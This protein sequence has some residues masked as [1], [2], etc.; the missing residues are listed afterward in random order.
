M[1]KKPDDSVLKNAREITYSTLADE[2]LSRGRLDYISPNVE[3]LLGYKPGDF[4]ANR[5]LWSSIIHREDIAKV[6][7]QSKKYSGNASIKL[8]Y[9]VRHRRTGKYRT[10]EDV[11]NPRLDRKGKRIGVVGSIIDITDREA[12]KPRRRREP[13]MD[14]EFWLNESQRVAKVGSYVYDFSTGEWSGSPTLDGILGLDRS[15]RKDVESWL[16]LIHPEDR[17]SVYIQVRKAYSSSTKS[18]VEFRIV[19]WKDKKIRWIWGTGEILRDSR[20]RPVK[21]FGTVQDITERKKAEDALQQNEILFHNSFEQSAGGMALVG[22]DGK[23]RLVNNRFAEMLGFSKE[24]LLSKT[25]VSVAHPEEREQAKKSIPAILASGVKNQIIEKRLIRKDGSIIWASISVALIQDLEGKP[26]YLVANFQ[27]MTERNKFEET[28]RNERIILRTL[29][30][31]LPS[32]VY[33]KDRECRARVVN[34]AAV[35]NGGMKSESE[36]IGKTDFDFFPREIAEGFFADDQK[37][38]KE[39]KPVLDREEYFFDNEGKKHWQLT[40]KVP[41][42]DETGKVVGLVGVGTDITERKLEEE[43]HQRERILL[44]TLVDNLPNAVFVKDKEYRKVIANPAHIRRVGLSTGHDITSESEILGKTDFEVYPKHLAEEFFIDDQKVIRDGQSVI[45]REQFGVDPSGYKRWELI[46]KLPLRDEKGEIIGLVGI[47]SEITKQKSVE[48]ALERER[49]LLKTLIDNLPSAIFAKDREYRKIIVN[50]AHVK[51]VGLSVGPKAEAEILGKTDFD[52]YP[53]DL[54]EGYFNEDRDIVEEGRQVLNR[55]SLNIDKNGERHWDLISKIPFRNSEGKIAGMVGITTDITSLKAAEESLLRERTLLRTLIDNLP[56][57]VFVKDRS[58]R[59]TVVNPVHVKDVRAHLE[60]IGVESSIDIVGKTDFDVYPAELAEK[61]LIDDRMVLEEGVPV[62]NKEET[63][64]D[65]RGEQNWTLVSKIPLRDDQGNISG[66]LGITTDITAFKRAQES[67]QRERTL[68]RTLID[69]LPNAIFA[70]DKNLRKILVNPAHVKRMA[71]HIGPITEEQL[72]GKTDFEVCPPDIADAY[73]KDDQRMMRDGIADLNRELYETDANGQKHW[74]LISKIPI[75]DSNREIVGIVGISTDITA[76]REAEEALRKSEAELRTLFA[77]MKDVVFVVDG[78]GRYLEVAP[79][80]PTLLYRPPHVLLGRTLYEIFPKDQADSYLA[81][82]R[83]ALR[84]GDLQSTEYSLELSG[85]TVWFDASVSRMADNRVLW[86]ARDITRRRTAEDALRRSEETLARIASSIDDVIY[87][88]DGTTGEFAYISP[89][90]ERKFG[91]SLSD[92]LKMGGRWAFISNVIMREDVPLIDPVVTVMQ[93]QV[94]DDV[95]VWENWWRCKDGTLLFIEDHSVPTYENGKLV[96]VDGVLRDVT[97]KKSAEDAKQRERILLRTLID[98]FPHAIYVKDSNYKTIIANPASLKYTGLP[99]EADVIGKTDFDV[100][101]LE[102]AEKFFTDDQKVIRDGQP[103]LNREES[104]IDVEGKKHWLLTSKIPLRDQNGAITGLVG[105]GMDVTE[106]K[107]IDEALRQSEAELRALF[108]SMNDVILVLGRDGKFLKAAPAKDTL[109]YRPAAEIVGKTNREI[110]PK[111][112]SDFFMSIIEKTLATNT[113]QNVEY[114][115]NI[116]GKE[117]WRAAA[118]SPMSE[119]SVLWVA[120]DIT[121]RKQME[122][123][124][125]ESERKY[126]ELVENALVGVY[127]TT[128][129]GEFIYANKAMADIL[130]YDSPQMMMSASLPKLYKSVREWESF[131]EDLKKDG[132]TGKSKEF[133]F[134]TRTGKIRNVLLSASFDGDVVSGMVKDITEIRT[135]ERQFIQTQ[136]LEGLGNIAAGIAHDFNNILGVILGYSELLGQ[137]TYEIQKFDRGIKAITKAADRGKSLVQQLLT[138]ARKTETTF[139]SINLN[140]IIGETERLIEETFPKTIEITTDCRSDIPLVMADSTQIQQVLLNLCVNSRDAM[141]KGGTLTI[142]TRTVHGKTLEERHFAA[143]D[144]EYVE[145]RISDTGTGMDK[146]TRQH[147]FEPF[148]TTKDVGKGTGLGLSVVYGI[149]E[150]HRGFI[151]VTSELGKGTDVFVY[152]PAQREG[153]SGSELVKEMA[154]DF[155]TGKGTVLVIEDEEMLRDLLTTILTSKG[156]EI[157]LSHDGEEGIETF[158]REKDRIAVVISDLGLPKMSG[159]SVVSAVKEINPH[160]RVVIASGFIDPEVKASL[161]KIGV[162]QFIQKPYKA[163]EVFR[164]VR[165]AIADSGFKGEH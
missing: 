16:Q 106:R 41:L 126:R 11:I 156:Y 5:N 158:R 61:F 80:D 137:G 15:F 28:L 79:T 122:R 87:S 70:K 55:E 148:F 132:K 83:E 71:A 95:P 17:K 57:A 163:A 31:S 117:K 54:A 109:L 50:P 65:S 43:Q 124:I 118:V 47:T 60:S 21:M 160:A 115:I 51:R 93:E 7:A 45:N 52:I 81:V 32:A 103:V 133:E 10:V 13:F 101:P 98:N 157:I 125:T 2:K 35:R 100:Y 67:Q 68:M 12:M 141:S 150:S 134:I 40:S 66:L 82:I 23:F 84:S 34:L 96:R 85:S 38:I 128:V 155:P 112:Q 33:V 27:D 129:D 105:V 127:K 152:F 72:L 9:R 99:S 49:I 62:V 108:N 113:A 136:K 159:E 140:E 53:I 46:S 91:Y 102:E 131:T 121:E 22:I 153:A 164:A 75:R 19:R 37:V 14:N 4:S 86:V 116:R 145:V 44:R 142:G 107:M 48:E 26:E 8:E 74:E 162:D 111:E 119:D 92:V 147:I 24:E 138:F 39:G 63:A 64:F 161:E 104:L 42:C 90:F 56:S 58:Y 3:A 89:A 30:D 123:E 97:E 139:E 114:A 120:R 154:E 25:I 151:D 149:V 73:F 76:L 165:D 77:S 69:H 144:K 59:K 36:I 6:E 88:L 29:I 146:M 78:E 143:A 135:L 94:L 18:S 1:H 110:F 20:G 130:E